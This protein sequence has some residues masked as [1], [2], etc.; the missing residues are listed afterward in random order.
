MSDWLHEYRDQNAGDLCEPANFAY[1][2]VSRIVA[3]QYRLATALSGNGLI[4]PAW[5]A[6]PKAW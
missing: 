1:A 5:P 4:L 3:D 6:E 2:E